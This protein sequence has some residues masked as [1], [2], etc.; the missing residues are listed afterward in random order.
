[1]TPLV[2]ARTLTCLIALPA[3]SAAADVNPL[4]QKIQTR[5]NHAQSL[6]LDFSESY[7]GT[8]SPLQSEAGVLYLKKPGRM[9]W[10]YTSPAGK[11]FLSDGKDVLT[12]TPADH[13]VQKA[14]LKESED[15]HAPIAFLL[16]KLD[17]RKEFKS[18]ETRVEGPDTWIVAT[19]KSE[20]L[21]WSKVD[22][23]A[24]PEGE[25]RR[26]RIALQDQSRLDF[27]FSNEQLNAPVAQTMFTF[28]PPPGVQIVEA[29]Q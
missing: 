9:R 6:K 13:S 1:M 8:R 18:F 26:V 22:F 2:A 11:L 10:E 5:Y 19:P 4:L 29:G 28:H 16:G 12:Y 24:T 21:A 14:K 3:L 15:V 17:F 20:N 7:A 27:A 25:I 23:L